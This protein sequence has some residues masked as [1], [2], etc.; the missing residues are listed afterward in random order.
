MRK[1]KSKFRVLD[2][3]TSAYLLACAT[4]LECSWLLFS[5]N[6]QPPFWIMHLSKKV[7]EKKCSAIFLLSSFSHASTLHPCT[8]LHPALQ[9][10]LIMS[11][12]TVLLTTTP[13][14]THHHKMSNQNSTIVP[15]TIAPHTTI[16]THNRGWGSCH[17]FWIGY[18]RIRY[19][20]KI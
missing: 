2:L 12:P 6:P 3:E 15:H 18:S 19:F 14:I 11:S 17:L 13:H 7:N 1:K 16:I 4:I 20:S 5:I 9:H 8:D 10:S